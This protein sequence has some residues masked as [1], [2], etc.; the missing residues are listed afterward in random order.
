MVIK[1]KKIFLKELSKLPTKSR[2]KIENIVFHEIMNMQDQDIYKIITKMKSYSG[3]YKIR[4]GDYRL[5]IYIKEKILEFQRI[6]HRK[7][8][9]RFFP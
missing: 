2:L 1:Y 9:Y 3:Y 5:G 6:L 8:I 7:E 4:V